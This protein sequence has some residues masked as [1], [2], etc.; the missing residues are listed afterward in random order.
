MDKF[1]LL[2]KYW[3]YSQFRPFQ[4]QIINDVLEGKDV[5]AILPTGGGKSLCYQLPSLLLE[6]TV[7]VIS[8]LIALMED[9]VKQLEKR[10]IKAMY[11][12]SDPKSVSL[13]QQIDNCLHGNY[14]LVF[15]APERFLN[16]S[17]VEQLTKVKVAL[18]AVD[19]AHCISEWGHDFRPSYRK[20]DELRKRFP[21]VPLMAL[22]ASA[23][24]A[25]IKD[26]R[27][28]LNLN[29]AKNYVHSFERPNIAYKIWN[30][31]DK[32]NTVVQL[33]KYHR[34]SSIVYCNTRKQTEHLAQYINQNGYKADF[35]HG[36]LLA[37]KKKE[38]LATWQEGGIPH[39]IATT[40]F[41]MGIDKADVRLVIHTQL[42]DSIENFYQETGRA[43]RDG[44]PACTYLL[45]YPGDAKALKSQFLDRIP[46]KLDIKET[47]RDLC[48]FLQI[49]Y[50]EGKDQLYSL[51]LKRFCKRYEKSISK[52]E[53]TLRL[54]EQ[55]GLVQLANSREK[56]LQVRVIASP[57]ES[58]TYMSKENAS[59]QLLE[60]LMRQNPHLIAES[61]LLSPKKLCKAL[62]Y[63][64]ERLLNSFETLKQQGIIEFSIHESNI[65]IT[66]R[67]PREDGYT[68]RPAIEWSEK[69]YSMKKKKIQAMI[70]FTEEHNHC[71]R[72]SILNYFG[73][74]KK[75]IC[76][77]C[78]ARSCKRSLEVENDFE[79]KI[80]TLL[81]TAPHSL[82]DIKQ[83]LYFEPQALQPYLSMWLDLEYIKENESQQYYW[84]HE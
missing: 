69:I 58:M 76:R 44:K 77:Q 15:S 3:G 64:Q 7:F 52:T 59:G 2:N 63:S 18:I 14:K 31:E 39:I 67:I 38:K 48:N 51:D 70:Q 55:T 33:L 36:G 66:P 19:E 26:M 62:H 6:G 71:K 5:I 68:L 13:Q 23:T 4:E 65:Y 11:F 56:Q 84:I 22:T 57:N 8:P 54:F 74:K 16:S 9:Q 20:L 21:K 82:Q 43:G 73:E 37:E 81:K 24:P 79:N 47:Y 32:F 42:P 1:Q 12:Q 40:A 61:S 28:L 45:T 41:G 60:Y 46:S 25:V 49:A 78:S 50:G 75:D 29:Q 30:T 35:F 53:H 10:G 27:S 80:K 17:F 83:K 34:G 72:K